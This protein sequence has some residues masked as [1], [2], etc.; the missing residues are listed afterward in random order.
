MT[1]FYIARH[2]ETVANKSNQIAGQYETPLT[3]LG[4]E[5]AR[6]IRLALA[7]VKID[8]AYSSDLD[9][10]YQTGKIALG[11]SF[12]IQKDATLRELDFGKWDGMI[13]SDVAKVYQEDWA[14]WKNDY[15][16]SRPT[17]GESIA[18]A[19]QRI[20]SA[21]C[22]IAQ[23]NE[24]KTVAIFF[25]GRIMRLLLEWAKGVPQSVIP[26]IKSPKNASIAIFDV[27]NGTP[28][29]IKDADDSHLGALKTGP[30]EE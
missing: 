8:V 30:C 21:I 16:Q 24:G 29:L 14:R 20:S 25:H 26:P 5:Q 13:Y 12:A 9:R 1:R 15:P 23:Q 6:L 19:Y 18:Q 22:R 11:E 10:A 4:R 28:T 7:D 2:G 3:D 17:G 27:I